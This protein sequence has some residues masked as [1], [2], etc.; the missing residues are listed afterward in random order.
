MKKYI[1]NPY[2]AYFI[3]NDYSGKETACL[4][5]DVKDGEGNYLGEQRVSLYSFDGSSGYIDI[6]NNSKLKSNIGGPAFGA[7]KRR[8]ANLYTKIFDTLKEYI[9]KHPRR[10]TIMTLDKVY[11]IDFIRELCVVTLGFRTTGESGTRFD[12]LYYNNSRRI[13]AADSYKIEFER[14]NYLLDGK[15]LSGLMVNLCLYYGDNVQRI[16]LA[17]VNRQN[18]KDGDQIRSH[19]WSYGQEEA[20]FM[21]ERLMEDVIHYKE[22][23]KDFLIAVRGASI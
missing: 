19:Y 11:A 13:D 21:T 3:T 5:L 22:K 12:E 6:D 1:V 2:S 10:K 4:S 16:H 14:N 17:T 20:G 18:P 8:S 23:A 15:S 9:A 7:F